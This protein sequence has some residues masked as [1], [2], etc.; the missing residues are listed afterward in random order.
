MKI[1]LQRTGGII[2]LKKIADTEVDWT[3]KEI[4][5]LIKSVST[6]DEPGKMRDSTQYHLIYKGQP[7]SI[8]LE[9]IPI[10]Y[11]DVFERLKDNLQIVKPG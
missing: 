11:R 5:E 10:K 1:T 3:E 8:D 6:V 2:P 9:K 7:V 4:D